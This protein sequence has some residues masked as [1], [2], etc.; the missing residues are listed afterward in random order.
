MCEPLE[1]V[2]GDEQPGVHRE[3]VLSTRSDPGGGIRRVRARQAA[4]TREPG[5]W[6]ADTRRRVPY[7]CSTGVPNRV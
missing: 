6:C 5:A 2:G 1:P 7:E 3:A 4:L